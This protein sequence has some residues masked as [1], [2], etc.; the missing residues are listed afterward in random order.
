LINAARDQS[1]AV[2]REAILALAY[3]Q[4]PEALPVLRNSVV[5]PDP[6]I[7]RIAIDAVSLLDD[8]AVSALIK[9]TTD[10]DWQVRAQAVSRL[11]RFSDEQVIDTLRQALEDDRWQVVKEA[12]Q[13]LGKVKAPLGPYLIPFL[14]HEL[15]DVRIAAASAIADIGD[16]SSL[17][18]L[19]KLLRDPDTGA[20]KAAARAI[21]RL[22]FC[23]DA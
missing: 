6:E 21:A 8:S 4:E 10:A 15:A 5:D 22:E 13:S 14:F 12:I 2:R 3:L 20:Q 23:R 9:A 19:R 16:T 18:E 7:R 17:L 1:P 11:S